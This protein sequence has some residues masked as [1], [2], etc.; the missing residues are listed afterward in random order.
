[1]HCRIEL[2]MKDTC[3]SALE[4]GEKNLFQS[5]PFSWDHKIVTIYEGCS[6]SLFNEMTVNCGHNL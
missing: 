2:F 5:A 4:F 6:K 1:M 3:D